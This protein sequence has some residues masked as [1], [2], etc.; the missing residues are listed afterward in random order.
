[1]AIVDRINEV[2]DSLNKMKR[3][4]AFKK[5]N[6]KREDAVE[7]QA[8][9]SKCRGQLEIC[10]NEFRIAIRT[11]ARNI[12][13]GVRTH[14]DTAIQEQLLWDAAIG[15]MLVNDAIYALKTVTTANSISYGY[16][17]LDIAVAQMNGKK[18]KMPTYGLTGSSK[19]FRNR[20]GYITSDAV[21]NEKI[22]LLESFF[23]TLKVT[24]DIETCLAK[25]Y[26]NQDQTISRIG[27]SITN[28]PDKASPEYLNSLLGGA[29][30]N[31]SDDEIDI[32]ALTDNTTNPKF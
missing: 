8:A 12:Q 26:A 23:E 21:K 20:Y 30:E 3:K 29:G 25:A 7:F 19:K 27:G 9:L 11:Q 5:A 6:E 28:G 10:I 17:I 31:V 16:E 4:N 2:K 22:E 14:S 18:K 32:N 1:M 13:E 15:Y 24:G